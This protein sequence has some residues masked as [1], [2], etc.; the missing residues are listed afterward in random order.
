VAVAVS[1]FQGKVT[2]SLTMNSGIQS[3]VDSLL[4]NIPQELDNIF[5]DAPDE[6]GFISIPI[7]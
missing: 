1:K 6:N 2:T 4:K 3:E 5:E 7:I